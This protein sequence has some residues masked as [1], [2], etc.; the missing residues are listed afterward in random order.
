MPRAMRRGHLR[1]VWEKSTAVEVISF[2]LGQVRQISADKHGIM[3]ILWGKQID[4][5]VLCIASIDV[6]FRRYNNIVHVM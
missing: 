3:W 6:A 1:G 4:D 5:R 2:L